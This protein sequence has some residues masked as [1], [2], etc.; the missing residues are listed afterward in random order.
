VHQERAV[1]HV[2][3]FDADRGDRGEFCPWPPLY[4]LAAGGVMRVFGGVVYVP[5]IFFAFFVAAVTAAM[6]RFGTIAA[7]TA[8]LTLAL[9]PYL[10]DASRTGHI[11]HHYVEPLLL[12]FIVVTAARRNGVLLGIAIATALLVQTALLVA[13]GVAFVAIFFSDE[14]REGAKAF[15]IAAAITLLYRLT[16]PPGYPDSAWFLGYPHVALLVAAAIACALVPRVSRPIAIAAG[17]AIALTFPQTIS[18]LR[19]FGGDPWLSSIIEFQPMFNA[20]GFLGTDLANLGGGALLAPLL[21]RRHRTFA[22]FAIVY[23]LL[24]LS[25]RRFLVPAITLFAIGG[26]LFL[27]RCRLQPALHRLKPVPTQNTVLAYVAAAITI[28]PPLI[29]DVATARIPEPSHDEYRVV[30]RRLL[31]LPRGRVLGPWSLGHAI[32]VIGQ[33][34]VVVDN[35]GSMPDEQVFTRAIEAMLMTREAQLLRYCRE[36]GVRYLVLPHPAYVPATAAT[37][38]IDPDLYARTRLANRTVWSRLYHGER[39]AGFVPV[40]GGAISI[41]KVE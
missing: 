19:F 11:D 16:R 24:A 8:G 4:D 14:T 3:D 30:G 2:L 5:P 39:I 10:A 38:G 9:S 25:S 33:K 6:W 23:L 31:P 40:S 1:G 27:C 13:A 32:D 28:L 21:W 37:I 15:G 18:G 35:F 26:A 41:W 20:R 7:A 29:Y 36:R 34:P 17:A 12:L 22:M